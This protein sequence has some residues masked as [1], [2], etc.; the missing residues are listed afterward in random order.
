MRRDIT[1]LR[2]VEE[3]IAE[4][5]RERLQRLAEANPER[6]LAPVM[7]HMLSRA[8]GLGVEN[9]RHADT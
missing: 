2:L 4:T 5:E 7:V 9:G 3:E 8:V 6:S 1:R